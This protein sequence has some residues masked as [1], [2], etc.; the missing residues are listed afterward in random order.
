MA[1][2]RAASR[3]HRGRIKV[4]ADIYSVARSGT[5]DA[6]T[7]LHSCLEVAPEN[8]ALGIIEN[9]SIG[10]AVLT[11]VV[12]IYKL[13]TNEKSFPVMREGNILV[14]CGMDFIITELRPIYN[15]FTLEIHTR[16]LES[17]ADKFIN[18]EVV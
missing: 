16:R 6:R 5:T 3:L 15:M 8:D 11:Q 18:I 2:R 13:A 12:F 17:N 9:P 1:R 7:P 4:E 14:A 10:L